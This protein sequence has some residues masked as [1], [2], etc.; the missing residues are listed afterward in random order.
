MAILGTQIIPLVLQKP[1][2]GL[3]VPQLLIDQDFLNLSYTTHI[4]LPITAASIFSS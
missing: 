3:T 2:H 4:P 1:Y